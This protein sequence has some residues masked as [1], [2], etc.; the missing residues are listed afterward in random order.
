MESAI[1]WGPRPQPRCPRRPIVLWRSTQGVSIEMAELCFNCMNRSGFF[2]G[3]EDPDLPGQFAAA[4]KAGFRLLG[5][6]AYSIRKYVE[7]GGRLEG[8]AR[9]MD[10]AGM[11]C[12]ELPVDG[13]PSG[14]SPRG[15]SGGPP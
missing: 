6:D 5:P 13:L 4:R 14:V 15:N 12:F 10:E 9:L 2:L 7:A 8:L 1:V 3:D 11:R